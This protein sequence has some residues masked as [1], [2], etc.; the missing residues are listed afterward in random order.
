MIEFN[1]LFIDTTPLIYYVEKNPVY[2]DK[3]KKF[4]GQS[5]FLWD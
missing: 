4:L 1:K 3:L 2:Y 5:F